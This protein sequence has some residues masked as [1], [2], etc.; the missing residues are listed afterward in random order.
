MEKVME[1]IGEHMPRLIGTGI[2]YGSLVSLSAILLGYAISKA[3]SLV[4]DK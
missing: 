2:G 3:L 1:F 4:D